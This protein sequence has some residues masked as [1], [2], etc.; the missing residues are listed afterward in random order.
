MAATIERGVSAIRERVG[1]WR[2]AIKEGCSFEFI[3]SAARLLWC[4]D[5]RGPLG[6]ALK[7]G[8]YNQVEC[9]LVNDIKPQALGDKHTYRHS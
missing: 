6:G 3:A 2:D 7:P 5:D 8:H 1:R 4:G 9:N